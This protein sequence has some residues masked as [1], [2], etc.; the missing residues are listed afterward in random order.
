MDD[1]ALAAI[2]AGFAEARAKAD[3]EALARLGPVKM[4]DGVEITWLGGNCPV[5]GYGTVDGRSLYFRA[6]YESWSVSIGRDADGV[7]EWEHEEEVD[8]G[9]Y[10]AGWM[11]ELEA[12]HCIAR[13]VTLYR[14]TL[15]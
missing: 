10:A 3:A 14:A 12:R 8:G 6:R 15:V 7:S 9:M 1:T 4:P 11:T 13:A 2:R 5:Q